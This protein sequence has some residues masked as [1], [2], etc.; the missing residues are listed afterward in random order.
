MFSFFTSIAWAEAEAVPNKPHFVEQLMPFVFI[1]LLFYFLLIRPAQKKQKKHQELINQLKK[2]DHVITSSGI[3]GV[4][5]GLTDSF[6]ILE[7]ADK[8]RIR[9]LRSHVS[10]IMDAHKT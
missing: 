2:G 3:T 4:I 10:S 8:V 1:F 7:V 6:V 9:V 5:Y